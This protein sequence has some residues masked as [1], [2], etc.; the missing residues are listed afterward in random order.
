M[1]AWEWELPLPLTQR[2]SVE[3]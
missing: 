3:M 2:T 1:E